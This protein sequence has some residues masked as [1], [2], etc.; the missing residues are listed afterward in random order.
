MHK[1][2]VDKVAIVTGGAS[3]VGAATARRLADEG[4]TVV[5]ADVQAEPG[6]ALAVEL[7]KGFFHL[8]DISDEAAWTALM[9]KVDDRLGRLDVM[10]HCAG[11][12]GY[13]S[14]EDTSSEDW[15]GT[16]DINT[17]GTFLAN[18]FAVE[19]MRKSGGGAIVNVA[20]TASLR[21]VPHMISYSVSKAAVL[22]LTKCTA[23]HCGK[24]GYN[25]RCNAVLP[26]V[27]DT[28]MM[29]TLEDRIGRGAIEALSAQVHVLGR[30][31]QPEEIASVIAFLASDDASFI[32]ASG[33]A[34]DGGK[35]EI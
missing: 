9:A 21:A 32:T 26:G 20:S 27:V 15:R 29:K 25:I 1:R 13:G 17:F 16:L 35:M 28:P 7:G 23:I 14:I 30:M 5:I 18:K 31:A 24:Q 4:A 11:T 6:E 34:V 10:A 22:Q 2:F 19:A 3:G 33:Y 12:T 8:T